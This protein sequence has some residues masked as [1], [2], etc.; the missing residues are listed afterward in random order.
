[1]CSTKNLLGIILVCAAMGTAACGSGVPTAPTAAQVTEADVAYLQQVVDLFQSNA[2]YRASIDW[3][4]LRKQVID[5]VQ[6]GMD[7]LDA[8]LLAIKLVNDNHSYY[9]FPKSSTI[10]F[11]FSTPECLA[12]ASPLTP[13]TWPDDVGYAYVGAFS[14]SGSAAAT[15]A[16]KIQGAIRASDRAGNVGWVV[17]LR[18]NGGGNYSPMIAGVGPVLGEGLAGYFVHSD[19]TSISWGY[20]EGALWFSTTSNR[21]ISVNSPYHLSIPPRRVAVLTDSLTNSSGEAVAV[22]FRGRP[23]A[24]TFGGETCGRSSSI[25]QFTMSDGG[26]VGVLTALDADRLGKVYGGK[27][28]PDE[29]IHDDL[30]LYSRVV[31]WLRSGQ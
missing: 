20:I 23:D 8:I 17:D 15:Y 4:P 7:R 10:Y 28:P 14:G 31:N 9:L 2:Y 26:T 3:P 11:P 12:N 22:A 18:G 30:Q 5:A 1:M 27:L 19:G 24:R 16:E 25:S 29:T 21:E 6:G 13:F